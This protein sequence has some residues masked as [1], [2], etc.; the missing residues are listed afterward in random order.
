MANS[1]ISLTSLD[2]ADYKNSLK[3]YL[4]SQSQ[5]QDY[6]FDASNLSVILDILSYNT[7][8]NAFYMNMIGSEMFLDTA[9]MRDSVVLRAKE[10]NY[11][12]RSFRSST[13]Y[14]NLT[15]TNVPNNPL[16]VT[17]PAGTSFTGKAGSNSY[18]FS[19]TKSL[20]VQGIDGV[21]TASNVEISEGT[22]VTDTFIV[23]PS[24][25]TD[26]QQYIL[27][28]PTIDTKSLSV[29]SIEN[30]G[31]NVIPYFLSTTLL[32]LL[33]TTPVYFLQGADNSKYQIIFGDNVVGR[34][35]LDNSVIVANYLVTNG[36]LPNGIAIFSPNGKIGD[37]SNVTVTTV[38]AASGGDIGED[39]N[40]IRYNAPRHYATQERAVTVNDYETLMSVTYPEIQAI[41]VYGGE[42]V[43]PPQYGKVFV[44]LKLFNFDAVPDSKITEY[45][46]FLKTRA[47][48]TIQTQFVEPEY[49]YASIT[50]NIKYNVN[51]TTLQPSDIS[52]Y[53][54]SAIQNYSKTHLEN[55]KAELLYSKLV[56][57]I[58]AAHPSVISNETDYYVMKKLIPSSVSIKNYQL[59]FAMAFDANLP[60][61]NAIHV[62]GDTHALYS[63][64]FLYNNLIVNIEDDGLGNLR[65]VQEQAD[66]LHH[67]IVDAGVGSVDYT[68]GVVNINN[69]YTSTYF[70]DAIRFYAKPA[71][72]DNTTAENTIFEIPNDEIHITVE[73]VRQ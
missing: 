31:A 66:G 2:F 18:T 52:A 51:N 34:K 15:I 49:T 45:A 9:Q 73:I 59:N 42:D 41:S 38:A 64:Q 54:T 47:P 32:D 58:D 25:N 71:N 29:L 33:E 19:T 65:I 53:A 16:L 69:F 50:S 27:S 70:G 14:V 40:S 55:F 67:T 60:P 11:L 8:L 36:Q 22:S 46:A 61:Q 4:Q 10:L 20:V 26:Y 12:P 23:Q 21:F 56:A 72:K 3:K 13:A 44:S 6:N 30:N 68:T 57:G 62:A 43:T 37:S 7:Y 24:S 48:L 28:N 1:S 39:I 17:I 35:P 63:S 5:F